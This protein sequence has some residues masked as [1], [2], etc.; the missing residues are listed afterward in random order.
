MPENTASTTDGSDGDVAD[1]ED[2]AELTE[3]SDFFQILGSPSR[4]RI[5]HALIGSMP[6][7]PASIAEQAGISRNAFYDNKD[8]LE[9]YGIIEKTDS[10]G[11]SPLYELGDSDVVD[12]L[13]RF[14][15]TVEKSDE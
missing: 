15:D 1:V 10:V 9:D 8:V 4:V 11:N 6:L 13:V 14:A 2:V 7:N 12:A 3:Q 5:I